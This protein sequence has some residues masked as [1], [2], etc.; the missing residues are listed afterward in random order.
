MKEDVKEGKLKVES[1]DAVLTMA[2]GKP[3]HGGRVRGQ[4]VHVKQSVYF[5]LPRQKKAKTMDEKIQERVQ[6]Y[7][8]EE[9]TK[10]IKER[11]AFWVV[12][13]EKVKVGIPTKFVQQDGSPKPVSQ[14]ASCHSKG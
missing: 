14:Q 1:L 8:E 10:I 6:K 3:E 5:D 12:E 11:D 2:L 4:G 7:M 9:T 13:I